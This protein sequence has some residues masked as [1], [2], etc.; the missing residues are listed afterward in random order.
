MCR[1]PVQV[2]R[3]FLDIQ[4]RADAG[5]QW[6]LFGQRGTECINRL[7]FEALRIVQQ[8]PLQGGILFQGLLR[9][10]PCQ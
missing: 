5:D 4:Y 3:I 7:D 10:L 6:W 2:L 8:S 9:L 1:F